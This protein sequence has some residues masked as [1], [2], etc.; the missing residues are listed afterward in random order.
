MEYILRVALRAI[1]TETEAIAMRRKP[2]NALGV[3]SVIGR[4]EFIPSPR[5]EE[6]DDVTATCPRAG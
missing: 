4:C 2:C 5:I 1:R 6:L 3:T